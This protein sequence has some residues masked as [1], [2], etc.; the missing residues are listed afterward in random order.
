MKR[1]FNFLDKLNFLTSCGRLGRLIFFLK[2]KKIKVSDSAIVFFVCSLNHELKKNK[3][4]QKKK[5]RKVK[6]KKNCC[7]GNLLVY[8]SVFCVKGK[9]LFLKAKIRNF[10]YLFFFYFKGEI[11]GNRMSLIHLYTKYYF[12]RFLFCI[13]VVDAVVLL[14]ELKEAFEFFFLIFK[15]LIFK[16]IWYTL[17]LVLYQECILT[18]SLHKLKWW[19]WISIVLKR[20]LNFNIKLSI[21]GKIH[22]IWKI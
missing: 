6:N 21:M 16:F 10:Y 12:G 11:K 8:C 17:I 15:F 20:L 4:E 1:K 22:T 18:F 2:S 3:T 13:S 19:I 5:T 9:F 14:G 7:S